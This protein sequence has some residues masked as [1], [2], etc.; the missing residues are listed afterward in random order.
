MWCCWC[1]GRERQT[2]TCLLVSPHLNSGGEQQ[3]TPGVSPDMPVT[4][5]G[6]GNQKRLVDA[7]WLHHPMAGGSCVTTLASQTEHGVRGRVELGP[8]V[9]FSARLET[10]IK[11]SMELAQS[12]KVTTM[13]A[14]VHGE[15]N[16]PRW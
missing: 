15:G 2:D 13:E 5:P 10:R 12:W 11:E 14:A 6:H 16:R 9:P 4:V 7:W 1:V 3:K 8:S